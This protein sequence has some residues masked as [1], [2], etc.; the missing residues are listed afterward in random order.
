MRPL[1]DTNAAALA[2]YEGIDLAL[3]KRSPHN[4]DIILVPQ[5]SSD[6]NDPLLWPTWKKH[7]F[8]AIL[9]YGTVLVGAVGP[10][11]AAVGFFFLFFR[12]TFAQ[13]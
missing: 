1:Q 13:L 8:F 2:A 6:P 4:H 9:V 5:P 7:V 11:V 12:P 10:L 3:L